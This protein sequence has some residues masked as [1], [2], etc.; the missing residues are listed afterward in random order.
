[1]LAKDSVVQLVKS[2][3]LFGSVDEAG[4]AVVAEA[5]REERFPAGRVIFSRG[6]PPT[7]LYVV[8]EGRVRVSVVS[9]DG[10]ELSFR[11]AGPGDVIG[12]IGVLDGRQRSADALAVGDVC[13]LVLSQARFRQLM[14]THPEIAR[15]VVDFLCK[16]LRETSSQLEEIALYP[17]E[18]R[19]ARFLL[20]ALRMAGRNL[21]EKALLIDLRM[22]QAEI[23]LLLGT[24]RPK[25]T[26]ALGAL[27]A[28]GAI[29]RA[30]ERVVCH[31]AA[32]LAIA[33]DDRA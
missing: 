5:M 4:L 3:H 7:G 20:S 14:G 13:S 31:P 12:E 9:T 25:V 23:A 22:T 1:M 24:S 28:G 21:D 19:V 16:R 27:E 15:G 10:R 33:G 18:R 29:S 17:I 30:G 32:L 26:V 6:D 2:T 11:I 8:A